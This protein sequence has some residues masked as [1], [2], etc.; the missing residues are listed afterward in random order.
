M[1]TSFPRCGSV[2]IRN[3]EGLAPPRRPRLR[4]SGPRYACARWNA[5]RAFALL[6]PKKWGPANSRIKVAEST[7]RRKGRRRDWA[8]SLPGLAEGRRGRVRNEH[9]TIRRRVRNEHPTV[10]RR[11]LLLLLGAPEVERGVLLGAP[12]RAGLPGVALRRRRQWHLLVR[13]L[14]PPLGRCSVRRPAL[15][16]EHSW[17]P[18]RLPFA[19]RRRSPPPRQGV[20]P[21]QSPDGTAAG[22]LCAEATAGPRHSAPAW[23]GRHRA[24]T[25]V[26]RARREPQVRPTRSPASRRAAAAG[27]RHLL[28]SLGTASPDTALPFSGLGSRGGTISTPRVHVPSAAGGVVGR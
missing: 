18:A 3:R 28:G 2:W 15:V 6:H 10:R 5:S 12:G 7:G 9:P 13:L 23:R 25:Q 24:A 20:R 27:Q 22:D 26:R 1:G 4:P 19:G 21:G 17:A 14:H 8:E 11:R 16:E